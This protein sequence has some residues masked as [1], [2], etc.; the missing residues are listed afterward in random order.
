[1]TVLSP[2]WGD[3]SGGTIRGIWALCIMGIGDY[4]NFGPG[5]STEERVKWS[6][7]H[8]VWNK[9]EAEEFGVGKLIR[10]E[11]VAAGSPRAIYS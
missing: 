3:P 8:D 5:S 11:V 9:T 10:G 4:G 2:A 1:M 6:G 7:Y